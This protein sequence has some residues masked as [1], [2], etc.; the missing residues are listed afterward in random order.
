M[1]VACTLKP[2]SYPCPDHPH[3]D[4]TDQVRREACAEPTVIISDLVSGT[5]F[6]TGSDDRSSPRKGP[7]QVGVHCPG[8]PA[9]SSE[10]AQPHQVYFF[11]ER[12]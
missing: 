6:Q 11:G 5:S 9:D 10:K 4:L 12:T 1:A 7:F 8:R 3:I 2:E